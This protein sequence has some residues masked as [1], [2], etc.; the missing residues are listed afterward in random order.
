MVYFEWY[1]WRFDGVFGRRLREGKLSIGVRI[2]VS[3]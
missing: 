1:F 2:G 3:I